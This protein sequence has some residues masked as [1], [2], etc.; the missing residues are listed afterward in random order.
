VLDERSERLD[1]I[2]GTHEEPVQAAGGIPRNEAEVGLVAGL[3]RGKDPNGTIAGT[4]RQGHEEDDEG[5]ED[6]ASSHRRI[7]PAIASSPMISGMDFDTFSRRAAEILEEIPGEFLQGVVGVEVHPE[8][9]AHPHLPEL[10]TLGMCTDDELT[11]LTDPEAMRSRVHLYHGSFAALARREPGLDWE[12]ELRE[13]ILHEIRHHLEDRAG[14]LDL[15]VEDALADALARFHR[16]EDL[17]GGWYRHGESMEPDTWR[18]ED[19]LFVELH[20]RPAEVD[21]LRGETVRT[22]VLDEPFEA[23][24][25]EDVASG[26]ILTFDGAGLERPGGGWGD[27]HLVIRVR[28]S[29]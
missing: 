16:G 28:G 24:I 8:T 18:V 11:R 7:L 15:R 9:E 17:P 22:T 23:R 21:G 27:L 6:R 12:G 4:E 3:A 19:D 10:V 20:V 14:I 5:R 2:L 13:T 1:E 25:P 29:G 26:E